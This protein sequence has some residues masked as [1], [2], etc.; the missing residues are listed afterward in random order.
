MIFKPLLALTNKADDDDEDAEE[1]FEICCGLLEGEWPLLPVSAMTGYNLDRL[2]KI[3][4]EQ[5]EV[6]R[7]YSKPP[8]KEPDFSA[9]FVLKRRNTVAEFAGIQP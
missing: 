8:G 2:K 6:V 4:F 5:L 9:P 7:V 3:V 1:L